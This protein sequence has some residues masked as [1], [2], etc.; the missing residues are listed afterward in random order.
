MKRKIGITTTVPV[1]IILAAGDIP[2]DLNNKF[3]TGDDPN[4]WVNVAEE[5]GYPRSLCG[6]IKGIYGLVIERHPVDAVIVVTQGDCSNT[7]SMMET[8][9]LASSLRRYSPS[10]KHVGAIHELPLLSGGDVL[11]Y[12]P[13]TSE[14]PVIPFSYPYN[15]D[16]QQLRIEMERLIQKLGTSWDH[17]NDTMRTLRPVRQALQELDRLTWEDGVVSGKENHQWLI[18]SSDFNGDPDAYYDALQ[19]FLNDARKR[20]TAKAQFRL[21]YIGI[22]PI[23]TDFYDYLEANGIHTVF[24]EVQRQFSMP[25]NCDDL[26]EQYLRYTYPYDIFARIRDIQTEITRRHVQGLIHYTQ[27]FCHRQ[28][29]DLIFRQHLFVS[30]SRRDPI[31]ILTIEGDRPIPLDARTRLRLENFM[32]L[33]SA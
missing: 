7:I 26:V 12:A 6:W 10:A 32:A 18:S 20:K 22:P 1:E 14:I 13:T 17:V 8:F 19:R 28:I 33:L 3:I 29:E 2:V 27:A 11:Q 15:R 23:F 31:P 5:H 16:P 4:H 25:F 24:N 9:Q 21:G 30:E